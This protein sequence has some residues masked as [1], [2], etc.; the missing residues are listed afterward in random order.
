MRLY[1]RSLCL[2]FAVSNAVFAEKNYVGHGAETTSAET[3]KAFAPPALPSELSRKI[4]LLLDVRSPG[5]GSLS[6]DG[7][8]LAFSW[9]VTGT[10][11]I[12]KLDGPMSYP[13][14]LTGGED[15][16][17]LNAWTP[18]GKHLVL[19]RDRKG[20]EYPGLYLQSALGGELLKIQHEPKV[21]TLFSFVSD[22][23]KFI[24]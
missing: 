14:Q 19:S 3:L 10:R 7:K 11:Q 8:H 2:T 24:Y 15:N 9:A 17:A 1:L 16:T 6:E 4:Q 23:S 20:E 13:I 21:Q 22:D 12:W 5:I 18:D